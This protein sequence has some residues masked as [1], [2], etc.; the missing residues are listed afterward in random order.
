MDTRY[1]MAQWQGVT[2]AA[3]ETT[4]AGLSDSQNST[5]NFSADRECSMKNRI[6]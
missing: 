5:E 3:Q 6:N 1:D 2:E 4:E